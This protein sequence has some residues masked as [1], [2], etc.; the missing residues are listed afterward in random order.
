MLKGK[1]DLNPQLNLAEPFYKTDKSDT[2]PFHPLW[3][4]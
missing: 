1:N 3:F 2:D 4:S